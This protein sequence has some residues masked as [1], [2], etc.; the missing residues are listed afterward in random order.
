VR[1]IWP[2]D[3]DQPLGLG[4][5]DAGG[6]LVEQHQ[7][8]LARK[9]HADLG[10]LALAVRELAHLAAH[11]IRKAERG[12]DLSTGGHDRIALER[13][14]APRARDFPRPVSPLITEGTCVFTPMPRRTM[15]C[16]DQPVTS[17]PRN[18]HPPARLRA[19]DLPG[20]RLEERALAGAV[21]SRSGSAARDRAARS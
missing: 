2:D 13:A 4:G 18:N 12:D 15:R 16:V 21:R 3:R 11:E 8:R 14:G 9:D 7:P 1:L 20:D 6:R 19:A 10:E 5:G 17:W